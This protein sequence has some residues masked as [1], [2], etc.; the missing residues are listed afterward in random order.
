MALRR[1]LEKLE[2]AATPRAPKVV[3]YID[4]M[5]GSA[6]CRACELVPD[7]NPECPGVVGCRP[8]AEVQRATE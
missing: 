5:D 7:P 1:R 4:C 2:E 6:D 3:I 8:N